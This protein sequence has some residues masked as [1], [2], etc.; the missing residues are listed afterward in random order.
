VLVNESP[1]PGDQTNP[2]EDLPPDG[3]SGETDGPDVDIV[4]PDIPP[5]P[6]LP[7]T[8]NLHFNANGGKLNPASPAS[9]SLTAGEKA[10]RPAN[11]SRSGYDFASWNAAPD[12]S[13]QTWLFLPSNDA[14][15]MPARDQTLYAIWNKKT[16][17]PG[18]GP[19]PGTD[20]EP[21]PP[22]I[23]PP[24][25]DKPIPPIDPVTPVVPDKPGDDDSG[26]GTGGDTGGGGNSGGGSG[27]GNGGGGTGGGGLSPLPTDEGAGGVIDKISEN[28]V[29]PINDTIAHKPAN[30][31]RGDARAQ[32][33]NRL[34]ALNVPTMQIGGLEIPLFGPAGF[35][36]WALVNL[37]L[38]LVCLR[39]GL[40]AAGLAWVE[41]S[42]RYSE[43]TTTADAASPTAAAERERKFRDRLRILSA[44]VGILSLAVFFI[45]ENIHNLMVLVDIWTWLMLVITLAQ[46]LIL[47]RAFRKRSGDVDGRS[48][49][50]AALTTAK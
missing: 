10:S 23:I 34:K 2:D 47:R 8:F 50:K 19:E 33:L 37:L 42:N 32:T 3:P 24:D 25:D 14:T 38:A 9:Q 41:K 22:I 7:P 39:A 46:A 44:A 12:G 6:P 27:G 43:Q 18:P 48:V 13:G 15:P 16:P 28:P 36:T 31:A 40:S 17:G 26:G 30:P 20:P 1:N 35:A 5:A 4:P 21:E 49:K 11:P 45:T 29:K